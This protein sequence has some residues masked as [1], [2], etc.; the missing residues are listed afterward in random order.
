MYRTATFKK[1]DG[2]YCLFRKGEKVSE[3]VCSVVNQW[4]QA[5]Y[6]FGRYVSVIDEDGREFL[7]FKRLSKDDATQLSA[8]I[9]DKIQIPIEIVE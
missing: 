2:E 7:L 9:A 1:V 6:N 5:R 3:R 4:V 8:I